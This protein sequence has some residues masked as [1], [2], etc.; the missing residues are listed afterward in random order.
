MNASGVRFTYGAGVPAPWN[1]AGRD[2]STPG[3]TQSNG[4]E[5]KETVG[6]F[7][8]TNSEEPGDEDDGGLASDDPELEAGSLIG[9]LEDTEDGVGVGLR[10]VLLVHSLDE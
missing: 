1:S 6:D 7:A 9:R 4:K 5:D 10:L 2:A 3:G 8:V